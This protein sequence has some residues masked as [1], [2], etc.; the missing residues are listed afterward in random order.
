VGFAP[1][2]RGNGRLHHCWPSGRP[3]GIVDLDRALEGAAVFMIEESAAACASL[4]KE[5]P[6][7]TITSAPNVV[8][9]YDWRC[10]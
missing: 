8:S 10:Y 9:G 5:V 4:T 3:E 7:A 6:P 2:A 1:N